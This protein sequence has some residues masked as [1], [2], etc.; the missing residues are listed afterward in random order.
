MN[1]SIQGIYK[2]NSLLNTISIADDIYVTK[3]AFSMKALAII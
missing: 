1:D 2:S 3:K